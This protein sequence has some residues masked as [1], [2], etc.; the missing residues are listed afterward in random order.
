MKNLGGRMGMAGSGIVTLSLTVALVAA[1]NRITGFNLFTLTLWSVV[2]AGAILTGAAAAS[3][4]HLGSRLFRTRPTWLLHAI[5]GAALAQAAIYSDE[6]SALILDN[7]FRVADRIGFLNYLD[8]R[9]T[10]GYL[11][12]GPAQA[13][14]RDIGA[15]GYWLALFQ[16]L[17]F[18]LGGLGALVFVGK[19]PACTSCSRHLRRLAMGTQHFNDPD[20]FDT[21]YENVLSLPFDGP[22]FADWMTYDPDRGEI[23]EG[24]LLVTSTLL[25]CPHCRCQHITQSIRIMRGK[26]WSSLPKLARSMAIPCDVD[27]TPVFRRETG[28]AVRREAA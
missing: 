9:L 14:A 7:G 8:I 22:E 2:P 27:L 1:V 10:T 5:V 11:R 21:Y 12:S 3:G 18:I 24:S 23:R 4:I 16:F 20:A 25:D 26:E 15:L 17:G 13:S 6:Y 28:R 19:R